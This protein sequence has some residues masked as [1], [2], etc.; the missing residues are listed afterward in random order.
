MCDTCVICRESFTVEPPLVAGFC[1]ACD[2]LRAISDGAN[3]LTMQVLLVD[4]EKPID[5]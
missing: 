1:G 4:P 5:A 2:H 3:H